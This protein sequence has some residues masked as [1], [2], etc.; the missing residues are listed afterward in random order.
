MKEELITLIQNAKGAIDSLENFLFTEHKEFY[1]SSKQRITTCK[2]MLLFVEEHLEQ[3]GEEELTAA[4]QDI[5]TIITM[6]EDLRTKY[7]N[8]DAPNNASE[9]SEDE[10][11]GLLDNLNNADFGDL[12]TGTD[13]AIETLSIEQPFE[14]ETPVQTPE[15][16]LEP[17]STP[18]PEMSPELEP[19]PTPETES[20]ELKDFPDISVEGLEST[21]IPTEL[22]VET[23]EPKQEPV[24]ST[25]FANEPSDMFR[26]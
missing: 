21:P 17:E 20:I 26:L 19:T 1:I 8:S 10:L 3:F 11:N 5:S 23:P 13:Q 25:A 7:T 16:N 12:L 9:F 18:T 15:M 24:M 6:M 4:H 14:T 2:D 22:V